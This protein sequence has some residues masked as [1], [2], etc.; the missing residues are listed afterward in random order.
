M[1]ATKE[2]DVF[3]CHA[4]EDK[5]VVAAPIAEALTKGGLRVWLDERE[6]RLGNSLSRK[7]DEGLANSRF[8]VVILSKFFFAKRWTLRELNGLVARQT[9][10]GRDVILPVW[11]QVDE[12]FVSRYS[13]P[14][15]DQVSAR[16]ADGL[17]EVVR[18]IV[19][20]IR[21][22]E[23]AP[24][25]SSQEPRQ[26]TPRNAP[27]VP[28]R[29]APPPN[30]NGPE[31]LQAPLKAMQR[32]HVF[33]AW[34]L[35]QIALGE[36]ADLTSPMQYRPDFHFKLRSDDDAR[37]YL[38]TLDLTDEQVSAVLAA[39]DTSQRSRAF[40]EIVDSRRLR[41]VESFLTA[42]QNFVIEN[43]LLLSDSVYASLIQKGKELSLAMI[44]LRLAFAEPHAYNLE[45]ERSR[46]N[47]K[48]VALLN[49]GMKELKRGLRS[50]LGMDGLN[51]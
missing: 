39:T 34:R 6:L 46:A 43:E 35:L 19:E 16:T 38:R 36:A 33:E 15:A 24:E 30:A 40:V 48:V 17:D 18:Q 51:D 32:E 47:S 25:G 5:D 1:T 41:Q 3:I 14:L 45:A 42:F 27:L 13:P 22:A 31:E 20:V 2:W 8:G 12:E 44:G 4:S 37:Q 9:A 49:V 7:I 10:E 26:S 21:P 50:G 23:R 11:H 29:R 28:R